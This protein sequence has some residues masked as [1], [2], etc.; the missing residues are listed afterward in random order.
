MQRL[1]ACATT[2][3]ADFLLSIA[4]PDAPDAEV[5]TRF[6]PSP[7]N[8]LTL[9]LMVLLLLTAALLMCLTQPP[10]GTEVVLSAAGTS[11]ELSL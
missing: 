7:T 1:K 11:H 6:S 10:Q 9:D 8:N 5:Q 3:L 2:A 4:V